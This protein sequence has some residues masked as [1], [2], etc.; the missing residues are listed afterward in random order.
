MLS[1]ISNSLVNGLYG[2]FRYHLPIPSLHH[3]NAIFGNSD[4]SDISELARTLSAN[5]VDLSKS[6]FSN[7]Q[8][9]FDF[10]LLF[11]ASETESLSSRGY[12]SRKEQ[13][14]NLSMNYSFE[15]T[16]EIDGV[17][18]KKTY[19]LSM[20]IN[21]KNVREYSLSTR[22]EKEDILDFVRK[23]VQDVLEKSKDEKTLIGDVSIDWDSMRELI[24]MSE[25]EV[26]KKLLHVLSLA[27]SIAKLM[28]IL[29]EKDEDATLKNLYYE[30]EEW[31]VIE[32]KKG[33]ELDYS[34]QSS[35]REI[36]SEKISD[37]KQL[38]EIAIQAEASEGVVEG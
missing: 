21:V 15:R 6:T 35:L 25:D 33:K 23:V 28:N 29:D 3:D 17:L 19:E 1:T 13:Q 8:E 32:E 26:G 7:T 4:I 16:E 22:K 5:N 18:Y 10:G 34:F 31:D 37:E 30:R 11:L 2:G 20:K 38:D 14:I 27:I 12:Y 24:G 9:R 36:E